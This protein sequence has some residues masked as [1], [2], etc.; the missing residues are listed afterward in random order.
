MAHLSSGPPVVT[1]SHKVGANLP[2]IP[3]AL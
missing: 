1:K 2:I 3:I